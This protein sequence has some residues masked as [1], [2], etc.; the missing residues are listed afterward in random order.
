[1]RP[2]T[3]HYEE[4][5]GEE[6]LPHLRELGGLRIAVFREFPYLYDGDLAYEEQYLE[7]YLRSPRSLV[8]LLRAG[9]KLVG[10]TTC[11]PM[12]DE[13]PEF[14]AP[15]LAAGFDLGGILYFGESIILPE[16]RGQ[17]AGREF[18]RRREAHARRIGPFRHTAFCAVERP[19]DHPRRPQG[20]RPLDAFWRSCGYERRPELACELEW[21]ELDEEQASPKRLVFWMK[22]WA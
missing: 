22:D 14:Q 9:E 1:M 2:D 15:F 21:K 18:F 13:S 7:A 10:A 3:F 19:E 17:G 11:L 16:W 12:A 6:L 20:Y 8:V 5:R 4:L